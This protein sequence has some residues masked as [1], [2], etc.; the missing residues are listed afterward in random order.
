VSFM[1]GQTTLS[2]ERSPILEL[3]DRLG[4][5]WPSIMKSRSLTETVMRTLSDELSRPHLTPPDT[6]LVVYGSLARGEFTEGSDID[7]TLLVDGSASADHPVAAQ[8]ISSRLREL[9]LA[10]PAD[11]G[12]FGS[13]TFS[14]DLIHRIGGDDDTNHNTTQRLLLLLESAPIGDKSAY[15]RVLDSVLARYVGEDMVSPGDTAYRVPR[16]LQNDISRY[17]RTMAVD[18]A[19]KR[20]DRGPQGWALRVAKL[21]MSRKLIY[22]AGLLTCF[23]CD[24]AFL[25]PRR[26]HPWHDA[27]EVVRH[28]LGL[29]Q[30]TPLDIVATVVL[31]YFGELSGSARELFGAYD[32]FLEVLHDEDRRKHLKA[33]V[34]A[35]ADSDREYSHVRDLGKQFQNALTAMFFSAD[36][37]LRDLSIDYGVF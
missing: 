21:R 35:Q 4:E 26:S 9:N 17:W 16:F 31:S 27:H 24:P 22:A 10:P 6:T 15:F 18:F 33:L 29:V 36:T 34:P 25:E 2:F 14:H 32:K 7:W 30:T 11:G 3:Q 5:Q 12:A 23:L 19:K 20:R 13:L 28:L 8:R 1:F 37:P